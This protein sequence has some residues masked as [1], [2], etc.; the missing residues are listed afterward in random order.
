MRSNWIARSN[1]ERRSEVRHDGHAIKTKTAR[2]PNQMT[3]KTRLVKKVLREEIR[4]MARQ[5]LFRLVQIEWNSASL[6]RYLFG[7]VESRAGACCVRALARF[8]IGEQHAE[9]GRAAH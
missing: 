4:F 5:A 3:G 8:V 2:K 1:R 9:R 6:S 7:L